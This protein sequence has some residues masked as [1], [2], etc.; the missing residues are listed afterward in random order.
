MNSDDGDNEG[1]RDGVRSRANETRADAERAPTNANA[2]WRFA[3]D[4][5]GPGGVIEDTHTPETEP[6]EP[7][8]I[9]TEHAVFVAL[10]SRSRWACSSSDSDRS[11]SRRVPLSS[12]TAVVPYRCRPAPPS[13]RTTTYTPAAVRPD[14]DVLVQSGLLSGHTPLLLTAGLLL[15]LDGGGAR[16]GRT[17]SWSGSH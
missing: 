6:I 15:S 10:G 7:E 11:P 4:E 16:A 9:D 2:Q 1:K 13:F 17:S 12:R 14:M 5:V 3:V 8:S